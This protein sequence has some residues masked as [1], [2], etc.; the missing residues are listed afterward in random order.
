MIPT[1]TF[2]LRSSLFSALSVRN[3]SCLGRRTGT[4]WMVMSYLQIFGRSA[5][6]ELH[7]QRVFLKEPR[8]V[9]QP[10]VSHRI[11]V[12]CTVIP[13]RIFENWRRNIFLPH[14]CSDLARRSWRH[15]HAPHP[16]RRHATVLR[17]DARETVRCVQAGV[18]SGHL[19]G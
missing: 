15:A 5:L 7:L 1:C 9:A 16:K 17:R 13:F 19:S 6:K 12:S 3:T 11:C 18:Q 4:P 10:A 8:S 2:G 14:R